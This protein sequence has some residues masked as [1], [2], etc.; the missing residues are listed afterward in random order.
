MK[1]LLKLI[2]VAGGIFLAL[3]SLTLRQAARD[4]SY[5]VPATTAW[6]PSSEALFKQKCAK[7]HGADGSGDTSL[8]RIFNAPDF[9]DNSWWAKHSGAGELVNVI[10]RGKKNMPAF[11]RKLT[12]AQIA[13]LAAYVQHFRH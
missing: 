3:N 13:G 11:G 10:S 2:L 5:V 7:C 9:T 4:K 6:A 8:G 12:K 1:L